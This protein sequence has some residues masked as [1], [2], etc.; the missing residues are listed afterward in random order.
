M[1]FEIE[2]A[3]VALHSD[4]IEGLLKYLNGRTPHRFTGV[5]RFARPLLKNVALADSWNEQDS[6]MPDAPIESTLCALLHESGVSFVADDTRGDA[7]VCN[8]PQLD[9]TP[10]GAYCGVMLRGPGGEALGSLCHFDMKPCSVRH[11]EGRV[12]EAVARWL[13]DEHL[14][15]DAVYR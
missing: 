13:E 6:L 3:R 14:L 8:S 11:G 12:L 5:F 10:V 9:G 2:H 15:E 4:G 1:I 7:R